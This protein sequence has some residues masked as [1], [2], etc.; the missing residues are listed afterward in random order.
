[1]MYD[2]DQCHIHSNPLQF[3]C[4]CFHI[5]LHVNCFDGTVLNMCVYNIVNIYHVGT[6]GVDECMIM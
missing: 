5:I 2:T 6:H 3:V 1:M 4:V